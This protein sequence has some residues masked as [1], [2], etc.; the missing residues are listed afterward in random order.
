LLV[1]IGQ[2]PPKWEIEDVLDA[3]T[4]SAV[5]YTTRGLPTSGIEWAI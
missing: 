4:P 2:K 1:T 3:V 5:E